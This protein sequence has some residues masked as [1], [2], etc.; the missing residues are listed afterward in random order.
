[1]GVA[2]LRLC[3]Y[4]CFILEEIVSGRHPEDLMIRCRDGDVLLHKPLIAL[5][6]SSPLYKAIKQNTQDETIQIIVP[7]VS[8]LHAQYLVQILYTGQVSGLTEEDVVEVKSLA[9]LFK[10]KSAFSLSVTDEKSEKD[11]TALSKAT[12]TP[13]ELQI[14]MIERKRKD[15][16]VMHIDGVEADDSSGI[17]RSKR[18]RVKTKMLDGYETK[19]LQRK[20]E[21]EIPAGMY[22][23]DYSIVKVRGSL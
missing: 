15:K 8:I 1:M 23:L 21:I 4:R 16:P 13:T 9:N 19:S 6:T 7:S 5:L 18:P 10:L 12:T 11:N 3:N 22:V 14:E 2:K 17:R 20:S